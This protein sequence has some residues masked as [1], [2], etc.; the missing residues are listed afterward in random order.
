MP[1][2]SALITIFNHKYERN[3]PLLE[4]IY[5]RAFS[6]RKYI[7]PFAEGDHP[8]IINVYANGLSFGHHIAQAAEKFI[9]DDVDFYVFAADDLILNPTL[10]EENIADRLGLDAQTGYIKSIASADALRY[11]FMWSAHASFSLRFPGFDWRS[12]LPPREEVERK[13]AAM[14]LHTGRPTPR[15]RQDLA[16]TI[17][18][19]R[20]WRYLF[21]LN[22]LMTG[23][24]SSYPLLTGYAD[25]VIV[26]AS[27]I[28]AFARYCGILSATNMQAEIVVPTALALAC[29]RLRTE[30]PIG[31]HFLDG[32][33]N[34][35]A[36]SE[37]D[38]QVRAERAQQGFPKGLELWGP[39]IAEFE[40]AHDRRVDRL[41]DHFPEER[42]YVHP[43]K[44]SR[45]Q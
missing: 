16:W 22:L 5:A 7:V 14:G 30:L 15:G 28:R 10:N 24:R 1:S 18:Q 17:A 27:A 25:F 29:E 19:F 21:L 26:P 9:A 4:T 39:A 35:P 40:M 42:L 6:C 37:A 32:T 33:P 34:M 2:R 11:S 41:F 20:R 44:L 45:W 8:S 36:L 31:Q 13:Y 12:E 38:R 43:I 3:I 23:Q